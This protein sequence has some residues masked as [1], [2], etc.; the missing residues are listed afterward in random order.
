MFRFNQV[1]VLAPLLLFLFWL[2]TATAVLADTTY[3]VKPGDT[4]STI[5]R[6]HGVTVQAIAQANN[7]V[8]PNLIYSGQVLV[9]PGASAPVAGGGSPAPVTPPASGD[10]RYVVQAGDTLFRI[11]A[12]HGVTVQ[13]I[14]QLNGLSN[15]N[16]IYVGQVLFIPGTT[17]SPAP[18]PVPPPAPVATPV[19]PPAPSPGSA[20]LLPNPSFEEGHYNQNNTEELQVPN[21]WFLLVDEGPNSLQPGSGGNFFRPESRVLPYWNLP[22]HERAQ[23][24]WDGDHTIK[25]FKGGAPTHFHLFTDVFLQPGT[26]RL[27]INVFP[28]TVLAYNADG[29]KTWANDPLASEVRMIVGS[30]GSNWITPPVGQ[31][32]TLTHTFTVNNAGTVRVGASFRNRFIQANNGWFIDHWS[33][34]RI[35]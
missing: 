3:T 8:N 25:L 5:A 23:F 13:A 17:G 29:S 15:A 2:V 22:P 9:I 11:A 20:N 16:L 10:G 19:S 35:P 31:R 1:V 12:R 26:Y 33:L 21:G 30:G 27:E 28:D 34:R 24:I 6:I 32:H 4:L 14:V 7:I 18:L